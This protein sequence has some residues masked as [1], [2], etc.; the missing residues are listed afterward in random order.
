M[1]DTGPLQILIKLFLP[2][3]KLKAKGEFT[4]IIRGCFSNERP[5]RDRLLISA[6]RRT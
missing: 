6:G 3:S 5:Y 4:M 1:S 2:D